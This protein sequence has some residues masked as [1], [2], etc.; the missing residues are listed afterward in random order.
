MAENKETTVQSNDRDYSSTAKMYGKKKESPA[1][2][3]KN[4][5]SGKQRY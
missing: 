5:L 1:K 2:N 4:V 3:M